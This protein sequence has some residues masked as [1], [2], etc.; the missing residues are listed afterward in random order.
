VAKRAL[1]ESLEAVAKRK[2]LD[3]DLEVRAPPAA[4]HNPVHA[5]SI[6]G[7]V[8]PVLCIMYPGT[9]RSLSNKA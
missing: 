8:A 6:V 1:A 9:A 4:T 3:N 7:H 2:D 5:S